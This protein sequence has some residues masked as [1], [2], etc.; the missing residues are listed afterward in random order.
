MEGY[1]YKWTNYI[2][3]WKLRYFVLKNNILFYYEIKGDKPRG[4]IHM[5]ISKVSEDLVN[6]LKLEI[7]TGTSIMYLKAQSTSVRENWLKSLKNSKQDNEGK[8]EDHFMD[9][10]Y[11]A[12][13]QNDENPERLHKKLHILRKYTDK[14]SQ[15]NQ[16]YNTLLE[17][18]KDQ[19]NQEFVADFQKINSQINVNN[20]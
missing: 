20:I 16:T 14:L 5:P 10:S 6:D 8:L 17:K 12:D 13:S 19:L 3:G 1:L 7:E 18:Y 2:S 9:I 15:H 11:D 4:K